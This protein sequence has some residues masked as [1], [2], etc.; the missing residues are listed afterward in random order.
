MT[1][2]GGVHRE[3]PFEVPPA[4][5]DPVRQLRG[6]LAAPVTIVTSRRGDE[7]VGLTVSSL[8]VAEGDPP[9]VYFLVGGDTDLFEGLDETGKFVVHVCAEGDRELADVF[10]SR[11]PAPG[12]AFAGLAWSF[13]PWGPELEG[14]RT[15]ARCTVV[16]MDEE[17]YSVLVAATLD[18]LELSDLTEPLTYFRGSYRGL[19]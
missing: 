4:D 10:A 15:R 6:R 16:D 12:G 8:F 5:R 17:T 14:S 7:S 2:Q 13:S 1:D 11:R 18:E 3:H 9:Y 19:R